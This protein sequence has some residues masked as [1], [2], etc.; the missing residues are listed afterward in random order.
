V[1]WLAGI[2][3]SLFLVHFPVMLVVNALWS[4]HVPSA[5]WL[6]L[7]GMFVAYALSMCVAVAFHY[8]VER[9]LLA[10]GRRPRARPTPAMLLEREAEGGEG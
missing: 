8:R 5:P 10:F 1:G 2:S 7:L 9:P 4:S 3:Y 6:S